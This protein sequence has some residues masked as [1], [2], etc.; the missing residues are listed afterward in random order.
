MKTIW[1]AI[2]SLAA[3]TAGAAYKCVDE[4]GKMHIGDTPPPGCASVPMQELAPGGRVMRTIEP[5]LTGDQLKAKKAD[6]EKKRETDKAAFE[7]KR[8]DDALLMTYATEKEI[9]VARDRNTEPIRIRIKAVQ[10]RIKAVDK[11]TR[12]IE[13]EMEFYKAGKSKKKG[14]EMPS[15]LTADLD[16][17]RTEKTALVQTIVGYEKE[18]EQVRVRFEGDK[19]RWA[20]LK[21]AAATAAKAEPAPDGKPAVKKN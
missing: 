2:F 11:R 6:Q 17:A 16:R 9:D 20:A 13:E 1:I 10:D 4:K 18:A 14:T 7:Q 19:Q 12:E 5:T 21:G 15:H 3:S 8:K